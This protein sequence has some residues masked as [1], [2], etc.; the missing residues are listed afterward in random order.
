MSVTS[1]EKDYDRHTLVVVAE[2]DASVERVWEL[3]ADPRKL[4][5][6]WGP[7]TYPAT[8]V[9]HELTTGG[10][11]RYFMTGPQGERSRG[12]WR[13]DAVDPPRAL[14]LT[15]GWADEHGNPVPDAP[16]SAIHVRL[17]ENNGGTRMEIRSVF[18]SR[19]HMEQLDRLG[20]I[21]IFQQT[22]G[23]MDALLAD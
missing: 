14:D 22:I 7:P 21:E 10:R 4:E 23:Q 1:V 12:W 18:S 19:E 9:E 5:R 8:F 2:F 17:A 15:D 11:A 20:A 13:F 16:T 6:W 3:W